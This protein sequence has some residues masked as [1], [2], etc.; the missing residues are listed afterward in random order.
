M[1]DTD[2]DVEQL[3][4]RYRQALDQDEQRFL[5]AWVKAH[6]DNL[7]LLRWEGQ[8]LGLSPD[9]GREYSG[10]IMRKLHVRSS[11]DLIRE[12]LKAMGWWPPPK[13]SW[14]RPRAKEPPPSS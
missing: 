6:R 13:P 1:S 7:D 14:W 10:R 9:E 4:E 11:A 2:R 3:P 12:C 8:L 5:L